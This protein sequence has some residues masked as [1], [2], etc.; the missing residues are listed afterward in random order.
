MTEDEIKARLAAATPGPWFA[1]PNDLIGGW[2]VRTADTPPSEGPGEV[3]D[4]IREEDARLVAA[5]PA[6]IAAL[7]AEVERL[8][9]E[10][11]ELRLMAEEAARAE[12]ANAEDA[13]KERAAVVAW[14][15][16]QRL[17][18]TDSTGTP[19]AVSAT[20]AHAAEAIEG[21]EHRRE[22]KP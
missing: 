19:N 3:A 15:R 10:A 11:H 8:R 5:A 7:L 18:C 1:R 21:G 13:K 9:A 6:D 12:N 22:E 14:L 16:T 20:Y 2:C 17:Y 4:F